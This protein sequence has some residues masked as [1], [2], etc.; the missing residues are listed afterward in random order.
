MPP[1]LR[2]RAADNWR[3]LLSIADALGHGEDARAAAIAL[4][5]KRPDEDAGSRYSPVSEPCSTRC[6]RRAGGR[7]ASLAID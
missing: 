5:A 1:Q 2:D 4:C 6:R 7:I 3:P